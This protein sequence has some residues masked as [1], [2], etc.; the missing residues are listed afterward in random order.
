MKAR[1]D[2]ERRIEKE[3]Q[4]ITDLLGQIERGQAF[5]EGLQEALKM[6]PRDESNNKPKRGKRTLRSGSDMAKVRDLIEECGKP[7]YISQIV[8]GLG[9]PDTK[10][11]R[12]SVAGSLSRYV[13]A[14]EIFKRVKPN[15]FGLIDMDNLPEEV[16]LPP[17]FGTEETRKQDS[18]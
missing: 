10:A 12:L 15:T 8:T 9:K 18:T 1:R 13:R 6:L 7:M 11:N 3:K 4:K 5:I 14:G 16:E 2:I 17:D